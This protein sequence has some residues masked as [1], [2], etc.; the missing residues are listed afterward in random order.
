MKK[1]HLRFI[2]EHHAKLKPAAPAAEAAD[3]A[4]DLQSKRLSEDL[5]P[6]W[7]D[8]E[9]FQRLGCRKSSGKGFRE[10]FV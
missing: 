4:A 2:L 10:E 8:V 3:Q 9:E 5:A 7:K 1:V 6:F